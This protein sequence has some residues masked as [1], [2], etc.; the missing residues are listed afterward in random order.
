[1][2]MAAD[3][4]TVGLAGARADHRERGASGPGLCSSSGASA[5]SYS[6]VPGPA[7][8]KVG[9]HV[10]QRSRSARVACARARPPGERPERSM[11]SLVVD[12][13]AGNAAAVYA[14]V[15]DGR[16]PREA[17]RRGFG[18]T[19]GIR[20]LRRKCCTCLSWGTRQSPTTGPAASGRVHRGRLPLS[21]FWSR[22][23]GL[24][25]CGRASRDCSGRIRPTRRR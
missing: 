23:L 10:L 8:D 24:P 25:R 14:F 4:G 17:H 22:T 19:W 21:A 6:P 9:A 11:R 2:V 3:S 13:H 1:M 18:L 15:A 5:I 7:A 20:R 16:P 12:G